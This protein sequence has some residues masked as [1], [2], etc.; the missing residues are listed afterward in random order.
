MPAPAR[1]LQ[2]TASAM[3]SAGVGSRSALPAG[4]TSAR[5]EGPAWLDAQEE[6][7]RAQSYVIIPGALSPAEVRAISAAI[8]RDRAAHPY[9]WDGTRGGALGGAALPAAVGGSPHRFQS[10]AILERTAAFDATLCH[11]S[12]WPL[13]Q[14]LM[15]GDACF[16]EASVMVREACPDEASA[17]SMTGGG[18]VRRGR[19]SHSAVPVS[20]PVVILHTKREWGRCIDSTALLHHV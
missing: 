18:P 8:D 2:H 17:P 7:F 5:P 20:V 11:P 15:G 19:W 12:V 4:G 14:R 3:T 9:D 1:R 13:I 6:L 16:D 10:V